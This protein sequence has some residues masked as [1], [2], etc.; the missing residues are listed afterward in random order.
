VETLEANI[1]YR[2]GFDIAKPMVL[3]GST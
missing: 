2:I 1:G 3:I